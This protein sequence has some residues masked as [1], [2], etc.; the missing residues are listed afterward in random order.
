[1]V[2]VVVARWQKP[3][4]SS[5]TPQYN[6]CGWRSKSRLA[7]Q[8][9]PHADCGVVS[10]GALYAPAPAPRTAPPRST[11]PR[12]A[13]GAPRPVPAKARGSGCQGGRMCIHLVFTRWESHQF[14]RLT[15]EL[16]RT[17]GW[18]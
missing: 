4:G 6:L 11:A 8:P 18:P 12:A 15:I 14:P 3:S 2:S 17:R 9:K 10:G 7:D 1:M 13:P 16:K 5:I